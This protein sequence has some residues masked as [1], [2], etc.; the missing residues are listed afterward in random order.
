VLGVAAHETARAGL[1]TDLD[2]LV[3]EGA[4][5]MLAARDAIGVDAVW[6]GSST[7]SHCLL[8][9]PR[10]FLRRLGR[11]FP[12][13]NDATELDSQTASSG[14]P[15]ICASS[16][17]SRSLVSRL[18]SAG[19]EQPQRSSR[20]RAVS[21]GSWHRWRADERRHPTRAT[22]TINNQPKQTATSH[23]LAQVRR[24][25]ASLVDPAFQYVREPPTRQP[26]TVLR[27]R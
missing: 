12:A 22:R 18:P 19:P 2:Q 17:G 24:L 4:R 3:R 10:S 23:L 1:H 9:H 16:V 21:A 27:L 25:L 8:R 7:R 14:L 5:R 6:H 26:R 13:D 20:S 11:R 15:L